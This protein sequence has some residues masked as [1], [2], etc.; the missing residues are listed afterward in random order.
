MRIAVCVPSDDTVKTHFAFSMWGLLQYHPETLR[1]VNARSSLIPASRYILARDAL[2]QGAD[3]LFFVDTDLCFPEDALQRLVEHDRPIVGA[4]YVVRRPPV[5][6]LEGVGVERIR[7]DSTGLVKMK[8]MPIG[9]SLIRREVF[10]KI[11]EPWFPVAWVQDTRSFIGEDH[12]F[13][14]LARAAGYDLW[15]DLDL[16]GEVG[17]EGSQVWTWNDAEW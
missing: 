13:C 16:S 5:H 9:F 15:C 8:K 3:A 12:A 17:H 11:P 14:E 1:I 7:P 6:R 10:E 2:S 4:T